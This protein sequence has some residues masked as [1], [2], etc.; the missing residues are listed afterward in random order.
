MFAV[1]LL[2]TSS[3]YKKPVTYLKP[4]TVE[5]FVDK[6]V[7]IPAHLTEK[8]EP[9]Y[10]Q[11]PRWYKNTTWLELRYEYQRTIEYCNKKL[12]I[13]KKLPLPNHV[14]KNE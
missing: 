13:I 1:I 8:C 10:I 4:T 6:Y 7:P 11:Y 3:C 2:L 14:E 12:E 9:I 5:V